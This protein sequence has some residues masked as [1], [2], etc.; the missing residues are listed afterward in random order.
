LERE[1]E[2][3]NERVVDECKHRA[4]GEDVG[5]LFRALGD[6]GLP[7][8]LQG[9]NPLRVLLLDLQDA[10][11]DNFEEIERLDCEWFLLAYGPEVNLEVEGARAVRSGVP[12]VRAVLRCGS[13]ITDVQE[14]EW[15]LLGSPNSASSLPAP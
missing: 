8:G 2:G 11:G 10:L 1:F 14:I 15:N 9:I 12:L 13:E 6:M 5:D 3:D 4:L 7:N